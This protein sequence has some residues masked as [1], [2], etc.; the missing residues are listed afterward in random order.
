MFVQ[1]VEHKTR[2]R[3]NFAAAA[4]TDLGNVSAALTGNL[5][6]QFSDAG[7]AHIITKT[8]AVGTRTK[9]TAMR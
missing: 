3:E 7:T 1:N 9:F 8:N 2:K 6:A 4:G 5:P